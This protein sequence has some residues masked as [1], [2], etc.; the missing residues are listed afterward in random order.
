M[1][2]L[3]DCAARVV[4]GHRGA[5]WYAPENTL[6]SFRKALLL[7]AEA[8]EFDVRRS[9]DGEAMIFHDAA[10]DRTT[11]LHGPVAAR[12]AAALKQADAGH[13][14]AEPGNPATP[15]RATGVRIPTLRELIAEFPAVPLLIE[16]KEAEVAE[17]VARVLV[18]G[19]ATDRA[20]VAG[21]DWRAL[22]PFAAPP[23]HLGASRR[24]I[25]RRYFG[26]GEAA[27]GCRCY[28]VPE[29]YFGLPIPTRRFVG[30][31]HRRE[32]TVHV[33]TVDDAHAALR[34]WKRGVNGI[35]TNRPDVILAARDYGTE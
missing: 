31:A 25:A 8:I 22:A 29:R 32:S 34:L 5:A 18:E 11:D 20:V 10:L 2:P 3:L 28:A 24:D 27:A 16:V 1:N 19:G 12:T 6:E 17:A 23:F 15:F 26:F 35:V 4:I 7:G 21:S 9:A 30:E 14:Y 13:H 33:W